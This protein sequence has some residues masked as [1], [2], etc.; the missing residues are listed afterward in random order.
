MELEKY[1]FDPTFPG[2][3][4]GYSSF[5]KGLK[6]N[7][8]KI[9]QKD[10]KNWL[11]DQEE[12]TIHR[13]LR[14][15]FL[16]NRTIVYGIDNTWQA[17][18]IDMQKF[19]KFNNDNKYLLSVIDVFSKYAWVRPIKNKSNS[20][21]IEAFSE[22]FKERKPQKIH[23]DKGTEFIGKD[24][25]RFFKKN[26]IAFY[27][28]E[29]EMK[30]SIVRRFNRTIK[31]K[32]WR[33]FSKLGNKKY[34]EILD[35]L[36]DSYNNSYHRSIKMHP[37]QV[38]KSNENDVFE[39][40]YGFEPKL[41]KDYSVSDKNQIKFKR[42]DLVRISKYKNIFDKG[43]T[44]NWTRE[45]FTIHDIIVRDIPVYILKDYSGEIVEGTF[46]D[47]EI[48]KVFKTSDIFKVEEILKKRKTKSGIELFVKWLG[49]PSKFNSWIKESDIADK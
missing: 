23:S 40:L 16:R 7:D 44:P 42:G 27:F 34:I 22:I 31:E 32:M 41:V 33:Y 4:S 11:L 43:Y 47:Y 29:S 13:P 3:F 38:N 9:K 39:N 21:I 5:S 35:D 1:Y 49:Y 30:A 37:S 28:L 26:D 6:D 12:Y 18:L 2:S 8:I 25:Q 17:D 15:N 45:I 46:Y 24:T 48:Q 36:V 20:S 14:K 19:S 10:V